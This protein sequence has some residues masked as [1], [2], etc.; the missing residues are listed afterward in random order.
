MLIKLA[1]HRRTSTPLTGSCKFISA[2]QIKVLDVGGGDGDGDGAATN[3]DARIFVASKGPLNLFAVDATCR[4]AT[5]ITFVCLPGQTN[6]ITS[7]FLLM[8][9]SNKDDDQHDDSNHHHDLQ[10]IR[11]SRQPRTRESHRQSIKLV[12]LLAELRNNND[13]SARTGRVI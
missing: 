6:V 4:A 12:V 10:L 11:H 13:N 5:L 1:G 3:T 9:A 2:G 7:L 8:S